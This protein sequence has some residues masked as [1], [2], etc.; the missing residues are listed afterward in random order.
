MLGYVNH[1][2]MSASEP[3]PMTNIISTSGSIFESD[4]FLYYCVVK[5]LV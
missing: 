5:Y 1:V 4:V 2:A 3:C